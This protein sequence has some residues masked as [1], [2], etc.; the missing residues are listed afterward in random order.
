MRAFHAV[1]QVYV[2][3]LEAVERSVLLDA[4]DE[5]LS[6]LV[7]ANH[8]ED[9]AEDRAGDGVTDAS[10]DDAELEP[11]DVLSRA[12]QPQPAPTD[13]ALRRL[14][15]DA[16]REDPQVAAEFRR[17]TDADL[18]GTK[19]D[20]LR[21][22][23]AVVADAT[24]DLVVVPSEAARVAAALTDLRLVT[25]ERLGV[26]TDEDAGGLYDL[27]LE[28]DPSDEESPAEAARRFLAT[29]H[30]VLSMLQ[31]SLVDLMLARLDG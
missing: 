26:R 6:L 12:A 27:V 22:L 19:T 7:G 17:L 16:S 2:A 18:R 31:E 1:G 10:S 30:V 29:V 13:P 28:G 24:P 9:R 20:Q 15:P 3:H 11:L 21:R 23:R 25:A 8:A 14:L 5:V 4:V